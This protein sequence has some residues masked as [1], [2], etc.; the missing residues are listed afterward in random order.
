MKIF[1]SQ[2]REGFWRYGKFCWINLF[3]K[4]VKISWSFMKF[5]VFRKFVES[6]KKASLKIWKSSQKASN[7]LWK[8]QWKLWI[9]FKKSPWK[10]I[11]SLKKFF[12]RF[13]SSLKALKALKATKSSH[14]RQKS[15]KNLHFKLATTLP[16]NILKVILLKTS[17]QNFILIKLFKQL[18]LKNISNYSLRWTFA[19]SSHTRNS[20]IQIMFLRYSKNVPT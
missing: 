7:K 14:Y 18:F 10:F 12:R 5:K 8:I 6:L 13:Q 15:F 3:G 17:L 19:T 11:Q 16:L 2:F 1:E 9:S 20:W 4:L